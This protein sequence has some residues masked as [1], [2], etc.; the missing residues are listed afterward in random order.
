MEV[1]SDAEEPPISGREAPVEGSWYSMNVVL[2]AVS[3]KSRGLKGLVPCLMGSRVRR[4]ASFTSWSCS[5]S[6]A[7][8][9]RSG[10]KR[11]LSRAF[12]TL[13][14]HTLIPS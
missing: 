1:G 6:T 12:L 10:S 7:I 4:W 13:S 8:G 2:K 5:P 11:P 9:P 14:G 3:S